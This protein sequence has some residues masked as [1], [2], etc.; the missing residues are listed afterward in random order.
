MCT[1]VNEIKPILSL[2]TLDDVLCL[3]V[4]GNLPAAVTAADSAAYTS[5][6]MFMLI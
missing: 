5:A 2:A 6:V 4:C 1:K 3:G